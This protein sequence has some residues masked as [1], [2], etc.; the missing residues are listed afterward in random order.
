M[1]ILEITD[2]Q[3]GMSQFRQRIYND[4]AYIKK[5]LKIFQEIQVP[6]QFKFMFKDQK[7]LCCDF[8]ATFYS[9]G[10]TAYIGKSLY[11]DKRLIDFLGGMGIHRNLVQQDIDDI[12]SIWL[13]KPVKNTRNGVQEPLYDSVVKDIQKKIN[14]HTDRIYDFLH[15]FSQT[16]YARFTKTPMEWSERLVNNESK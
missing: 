2:M 5:N 3:H 13:E 7:I 4:K 8:P 6:W 10:K 14:V 16:P 11:Y 9:G 1:R 15:T 12:F